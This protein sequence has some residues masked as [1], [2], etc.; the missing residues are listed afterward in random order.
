MALVNQP[1]AMPTNKLMVAAAVGPAV[2]EVWGAV[3]SDLYAPVAGVET[4]FL[5]GAAAAL[6]LGYLI[7]DRPNV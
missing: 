3:M 6:A 2:T 4:S 1:S 7:K 5:M